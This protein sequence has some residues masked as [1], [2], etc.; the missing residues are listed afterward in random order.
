MATSAN[1]FCIVVGYENKANVEVAAS[2]IITR[3]V[4][5]KCDFVFLKFEIK[6]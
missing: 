4:Y 6:F 5:P 2:N 1:M 3:V